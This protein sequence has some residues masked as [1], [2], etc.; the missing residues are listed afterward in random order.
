[1]IQLMRLGKPCVLILFNK[2]EKD[3]MWQPELESFTQ[4]KIHQ[5]LSQEQL[6]GYHFGRVSKE[7]LQEL[8][9]TDNTSKLCCLCGPIMFNKSAQ[10]FLMDLN[11]KQSEIFVF[12]G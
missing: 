7:L 5:V 6:S 3:I 2:T 10:K 8:L 12:Q 9:P 4:V 11:F 1:M